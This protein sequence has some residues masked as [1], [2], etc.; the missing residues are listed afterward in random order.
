MSDYKRNP[1]GARR[2]RKS[3]GRKAIVVLSLMMV[4]VL[5]AVGGTI[6]WLTDTSDT[7]TNTFLATD[8]EV[9]LAETEGIVDG[10]WEAQLIPGKEYS[11]NPIVTVTENTDIDVY[12]FVKRSDT[13]SQYLDYTDLL[14]APDW[15]CL[16]ADA[17]VWYR[18]VRVDD[19]NK[20][21][22]LIGDNKVTVKT[23]IVKN[24]TNPVPAGCIEMPASTA[25]LHL[26]YTAYAVQY[27]GFES[28]PAGAW[29]QVAP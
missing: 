1:R 11:K 9:T 14:V 10:E 4:L 27:E 5:A 23:S 20:S 29:A 8:I 17:D 6:A 3:M 2:A 25:D 12:L 21:W 13:V 15:T 19:T 22:N 18:I 24:G 26:N 16:D 28:N 7:V